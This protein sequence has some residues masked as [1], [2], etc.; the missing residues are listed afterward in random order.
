MENEPIC[1]EP[2]EHK[3]QEE[4]KGQEGHD[5]CPA[6]V[7]LQRLIFVAAVLSLAV[8]EEKYEGTNI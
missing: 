1:K 7:F 8:P 6:D 4:H 2:G 5:E 3:E